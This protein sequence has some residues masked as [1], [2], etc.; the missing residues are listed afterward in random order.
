MIG[1]T[2]SHYRVTGKLGSGGM[3]VVYEA[4]DLT[5][6]RNVAL[7]F[8]PPDLARDSTALDRFMIEARAAS[9]LNHPNICTIYAVEQDA[10]QSFI[11]MEL[12]EGQSL[13]DKL[14]GNALPLERLLDI[15]VQLADALDAAHAKGIVHR[16]IKPANI[17]ITQR[18]QV[19]ILDFGLAKLTQVAEMDTMGATQTSPAHLTNPGATVGT[20][21]YMSPEQARGEAIDARSDL[22]S[23]GTVVY[24]M[25]TGKMPFAGNTSAVI[26][27]ALLANDPVPV[28]QLN[29]EMPPKLQEAIGKL[30]EKDR[31]LRY[32]SAADLRGDLR[33]IKRDT[34]SGRK[35]SQSV[36]TL[37][38]AS[39]P[40][41]SQP[42][43]GSEVLAAAGKPNLRLGVTAVISILVIAAAAYGVYSLFFHTHAVAFQNISITKVTETR[44]AA[45]A[46]ISPDG[47]YILNVVSEGGLES[48]WLRNIPTNSDTQ[49]IPP[50]QVHY[51]GLRFS[52]DGN[53]LYF[54]RSEASQQLD[55][56]YR[57]PVLGGTP[58][59][60]ASDVDSNI[61][62]SPDGRQY[63]FLR[64]NDPDP[65]KYSLIL[66]PAAGGDEKTL[67]TGPINN[68]LFDPSWSPDGK[69][70]VGVILQPEG[71]VTGLVAIDASSGRQKVFF[72]ASFGILASPVWLPDG[73]G[74]LYL[75][76]D[77]SS[78]WTR[79]QIGFVSYP[80]GKSRA[81]TRDINNYSDLSLS[82]DGHTLATV[83]N[84]SEWD[85]FLAPVDGNAEPTQL[86]SGKP[87]SD[88]AWT[89]D[90]KLLI[91]QD[92]MLSSM[93]TASSVRTDLMSPAQGGLAAE[94]SACA[95]GRY[96]VATIAGHGGQRNQVIG[97]MDTNGGNLKL[98]TDGKLQNNP[99]CSPDG[100]WVVYRDFSD[101]NRL[102]KVPLE[103]GPS[104][105]ISDLFVASGM[106][107]SPDGNLVAF[108]TFEHVGEH[109]DKLALVPIN[110]T[111]APKI[112]DFQHSPSGPLRFSHDGKAITYPVRKG[113]VDNLWLQPLDGSP[114][115][116]LTNFK[117]EH[118]G[119]SFGW[120]FDATKL[121]IIRGHT[122]S[123]V[124]LI[125]DTQ[126]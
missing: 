72:R 39:A 71:A 106:D 28:V 56:L 47:K 121:A 67:T 8:L 16:D 58:Q 107:V 30:L 90:G 18:N 65:D 78:N 46:A 64:D 103:G 26:F 40:A 7:K 110:S 79:N 5:L 35:L 24:Q 61:T 52:P 117:S 112:L 22:F 97:R 115:H 20:I 41:R 75:L 38:T 14:G 109:E 45:H 120:S 85:L 104:Q 101:R 17:F 13:G 76:R 69:S 82:A 98:L 83:L 60:L 54:V 33:R 116:Q 43:S 74:V 49:V 81:I 95:N 62:F 108:V 4:L 29:P 32:Q 9:A 66:Q 23:L 123:D 51:A 93:E 36:S 57:A 55:I 124:V 12:L 113:D 94:P 80:D 21:A 44:K 118:I 87:V 2:I 92:L 114:G 84:E 31:D 50:A 91:S 3:G 6:G 68:R 96:I 11:S 88:F 59:R 77:Q 1:Q 73:T 53:Y 15:T 10:G 86:T 126:Q 19:K 111:A 27:H 25:A 42:P 102:M 70:I 125:R 37:S 105:K 48:L 99:V 119:N 63:A 100:Q 89:T 34:E 122:D